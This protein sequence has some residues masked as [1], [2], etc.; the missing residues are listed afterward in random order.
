MSQEKPKSSLSSVP[1]RAGVRGSHRQD[2]SHWEQSHRGPERGCPPSVA[3][4]SRFTV[5]A[6]G[7]CADRFPSASISG[8]PLSS[9]SALRVSAATLG[10][11]DQENGGESV[12]DFCGRRWLLCVPVCVGGYVQM[13]SPEP[14]SKEGLPHGHAPCRA[15][16]RDL[17]VT[18]LLL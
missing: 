9:A 5:C 4:R 3:V 17:C 11:R 16:P 15:P 6:G 14:R 8:L 2:S 18:A 10:A 12:A 1:R 13:H 7:P